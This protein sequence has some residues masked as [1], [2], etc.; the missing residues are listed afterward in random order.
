MRARRLLES[1]SVRLSLAVAIVSLIVLVVATVRA[2]RVDMTLPALS[3]PVSAPIGTV[4]RATATSDGLVAAAVD[5]DPFSP[6]RQKSG[7][8]YGAPSAAIVLNAAPP[9]A[10]AQLHLVGTVIDPARGDFALCQLGADSPRMVRVGQ[11]I[12]NYVLRS[13]SQGVA[14]F[15]SPHGNRLELRVSKPGS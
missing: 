10:P 14:S 9:P 11:S 3:S 15:D 6:T 13:I 7:T 2:L 12:G 1:T 5:N 4:A 8:R